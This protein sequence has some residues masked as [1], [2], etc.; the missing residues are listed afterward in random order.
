MVARGQ[1]FLESMTFQ[2]LHDGR[3]HGCWEIDG[4]VFGRKVMNR[5]GLNATDQG[6]ESSE[7]S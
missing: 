2:V 5:E 1:G 7:K 4:T 6:K 3:T